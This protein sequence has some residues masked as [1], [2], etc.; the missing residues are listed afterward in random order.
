M[1]TTTTAL[2]SDVT[3]LKLGSDSLKGAVQDTQKKIIAPW[4]DPRFGLR[5]R[6]SAI[7]YANKK[8][9]PVEQPKKKIYSRDRNL[10]HISHEGADLESPANEP[11]DELWVMSVPF[12]TPE[13]I[14]VSTVSQ[15]DAALKGQGLPWLML[16]GTA[17]AHIMIPITR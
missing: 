12:A 2:S 4:K 15:R 13:S 11:K 8:G 3:D 10:W 6:E 16:A 7:D 14:G 9:V 1:K 5:D 17:G